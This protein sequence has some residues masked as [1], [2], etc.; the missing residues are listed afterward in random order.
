MSSSSPEEVILHIY[1][2]HADNRT[3][4]ASS[5]GGDATATSAQATPAQRLLPFL[6]TIGLGTYHTSLEIRSKCYSFAAGVGIAQSNSP[7]SGRREQYAPTNARYQESIALG[8]TTLSQGK[9]NEIVN[10]LR[11]TTFTS[12]SYHLMNRNCNHFTTTLAMALLHYDQLT[13]PGYHPSLQ[14]YPGWVNR[15]ARTGTGLGCLNGEG[16]DVICDPEREA[17]VAVGAE[18]RVGWDLSKN[19]GGNAKSATDSKKASAGGNSGKKEELT[20]EQKKILT[21]LKKKG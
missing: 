16:V 1:E 7:T 2:L 18:E 12:S 6:R 15:L 21:K 3:P 10:K 5:S 14:K 8:T 11:D 17:Q 4:S 9:I 13:D 19:G 20:E